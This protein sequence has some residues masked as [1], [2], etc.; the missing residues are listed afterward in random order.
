MEAQLKSRQC[1]LFLAAIVLTL[2]HC[3]SSTNDDP[4]IARWARGYVRDS[5]SSIGID[6]V[7]VTNHPA[8]RTDTSI[9]D[10]D[11][12]YVLFVGTGAFGPGY[13]LLFKKG[14]YAEKHITFP[15][16]TFA[17]KETTDVDVLLAPLFQTGPSDRKKGRQHP[18][19]GF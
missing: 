4:L 8:V 17:N 1:T 13:G 10:S 6:S 12:R 15:T 3:E 11:G 14:G 18:L 2:A 7:L 16:G 19:S 9:S 5:V